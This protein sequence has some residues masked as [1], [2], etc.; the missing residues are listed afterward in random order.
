M[1]RE[2]AAICAAPLTDALFPFGKGGAGSKLPEVHADC[3]DL[4]LGGQDTL[5]GV[6]PATKRDGLSLGNHIQSTT[7]LAMCFVS[8]H[9]NC[10]HETLLLP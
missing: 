8:G 3:H 10:H 5:P 9:T 4:P 1:P 7:L 6:V 2:T